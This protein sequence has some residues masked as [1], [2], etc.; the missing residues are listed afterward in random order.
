[1]LLDGHIG[2]RILTL[3]RIFLLF[4]VS[5]LAVTSTQSPT[6]WVTEAKAAGV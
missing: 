2:V 5:R 6:H 3:T 4:R 1:M